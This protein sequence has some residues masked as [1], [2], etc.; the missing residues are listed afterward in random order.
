MRPR[1]R[2]LPSTWA[3]VAV[4]AF[5]S[6]LVAFDVRHP[7]PDRDE[8]ATLYS[9]GLSWHGLIVH[10]HVQDAVLV[11]Y[12]LLLQGW[13]HVASGLAADRLLSVF[14]YGLAVA[15]AGAM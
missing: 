7:W 13:N 9:S 14:G 6:I 10:A 12:Y 15:A 1:G 4:G 5:A 8:A 2:V 11:P 3:G